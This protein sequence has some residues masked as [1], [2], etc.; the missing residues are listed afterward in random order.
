MAD[1]YKKFGRTLSPPGLKNACLLGAI[2]LALKYF[3]IKV[4]CAGEMFSCIEEFSG[5]EHDDQPIELL[6]SYDEV[7]KDCLEKRVSDSIKQMARFLNINLHFYPIVQEIDRSGT[8]E[9]VYGSS[10]RGGQHDIHIGLRSGHYYFLPFVGSMDELDIWDT[11]Y[12]EMRNF[13]PQY[14]NE[15]IK[16][17]TKYK[18]I[19]C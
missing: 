11:I 2:W 10:I 13:L 19:F 9:V 4:V 17:V 18:R 12:C 14:N 3:N 6:L 1:Q 7:I 16:Q 15:W 8:A 5:K